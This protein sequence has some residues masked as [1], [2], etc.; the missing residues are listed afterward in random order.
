MLE[1]VLTRVH[2]FTPSSSEAL[3]TVCRGVAENSGLIPGDFLQAG[4]GRVLS[5]ALYRDL[6]SLRHG[7]VQETDRRLMIGGAGVFE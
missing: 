6:L 3:R 1:L 2:P 4:T 5:L 7:L